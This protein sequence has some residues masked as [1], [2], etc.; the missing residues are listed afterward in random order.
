M[1]VLWVLGEVPIPADSGARLRILGLLKPLAARHE[2][3]AAVLDPGPRGRVLRSSSP[4]AG[5]L[6][7][8]ERE[9]ILRQVA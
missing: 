6:E 1:K 5:V 3:T 4:L 9:K 7:A 2:V 8:K